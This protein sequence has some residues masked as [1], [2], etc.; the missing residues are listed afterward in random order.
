MLRCKLALLAGTTFVL[1][2]CNQSRPSPVDRDTAASQAVDMQ[3]EERV[4]RSQE[5]RWQEALKSGDSAAI[6]GFYADDGYYLP[7][8]SGGYEGPGSISARWLGERKSGL[9][10]LV[11]EPKRIEVGNAGDLAYEVGTYKVKW[12]SKERGPGEASGNYVTVWKKV[13]GEWKTA[14]Y[15]WNRGEEARAGSR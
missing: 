9:T 5:Q 2:A 14:A 4:I 15:I 13:G 6:G 7:Q 8:G 10:E 1:L 11:R 3:A 12:D